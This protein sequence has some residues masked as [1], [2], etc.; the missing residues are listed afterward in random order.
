MRVHIC[1]LPWTEKSSLKRLR[2]VWKYSLLIILCYHEP[3]PILICDAL[4]PEGS[5]C[6]DLEYTYMCGVQ[7]FLF[8]WVT[9]VIKNSS[10]I[11]GL[12]FV[13]VINTNCIIIT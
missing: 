2:S 12:L 1:D 13:Y 5:A 4:V 7:V 11:Q 10:Y 3:C 8:E 9:V 6:T